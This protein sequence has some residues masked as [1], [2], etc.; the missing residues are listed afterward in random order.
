MRILLDTCVL[1]PSFLRKVLLDI[2]SNNIFMPFWSKNI[3]DEWRSVTKIKNE[4]LISKIDIEILL[5]NASWPN[6]CITINKEDEINL[7]LPDLNDRHVLL[8]AIKSKSS[9]LLTQNLKDFPVGTMNRYRI[10]PRSPESFF[11]QLYSENPE[12][13]KKSIIK[14]FDQE[15]KTLGEDL[16]L[17]NILKNNNLLRLSKL[18]I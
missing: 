16:S 8:A 1:Y 3:L 12:L 2:A 18:I 13:L 6:S 15:K 10:S 9:I 4:N 14:I 5:L 17:K 11:L 7:F